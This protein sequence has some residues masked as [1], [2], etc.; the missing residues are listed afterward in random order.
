MKVF[1]MMR[2]NEALLSIR[3]LAI[4]CH[5]IGNLTTNGKFL[6][7]S[8]VSGWSSGPNDMSMSNHFI[9]L[10]GSMR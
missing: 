6:L 2:F 8:S 7:D 10:P 5:P 4:L 9:I 1:L 3:V